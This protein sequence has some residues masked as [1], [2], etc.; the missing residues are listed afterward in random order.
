M[1]RN[2][3]LVVVE[4]QGGVEVEVSFVKTSRIKSRPAQ[5]DVRVLV[6]PQ[7]MT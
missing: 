7:R 2:V 3:S 1:L 6:S 5:T 4:A